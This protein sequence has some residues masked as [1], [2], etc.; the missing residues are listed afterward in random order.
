[1]KT[2]KRFIR[3]TDKHILNLD[4]FEPRVKGFCKGA[5]MVLAA[6]AAVGYMVGGYWVLWAIGG[7]LG[8]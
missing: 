1:M 7:G 3:L 5:L 4:I 2:R 6:G 8:V